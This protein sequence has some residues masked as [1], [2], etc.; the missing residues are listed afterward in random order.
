MVK[1]GKGDVNMSSEE[2][3]LRKA[4]KLAMEIVLVHCD[5][6]RDQ[7]EEICLREL[8]KTFRYQPE[9]RLRQMFNFYW[10]HCGGKI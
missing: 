10:D 6:P 1:A 7:A 4:S 8:K 9:F 3:E 2:T 5:L